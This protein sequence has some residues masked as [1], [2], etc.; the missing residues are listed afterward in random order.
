[1]SFFLSSSIQILCLVL[2]QFLVFTILISIPRRLYN[3]KLLKA[4]VALP[5]GIIGMFLIMFKLK[6]A[7]KTFIHTPHSTNSES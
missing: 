4:L 5:K 7:N 1:L 3:V 2:L 6:G